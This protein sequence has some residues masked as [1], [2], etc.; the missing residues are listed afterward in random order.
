[1]RLWLRYSRGRVTYTGRL[2]RAPFV[3]W[4][5]TTEGRTVLDRIA[6][7]IRFSLIGR[8]LAARHRVWRRLVAM[9]RDEAVVA[10]VQSEAQ[11]YLERPGRFA[12]ADGLPRIG[13]SLHRLVVIPRVLLNGAAYRGIAGKLTACP[14]F[15]TLE[16]GESLRDFF[17]L[18]L[19]EHLDTAVAAARP[20]P[21]RPLPAGDCWM[22]VGMNGRFV[23]RVPVVKS[24]PW[25]GH[26]YVLELTRDP[27][28]RRLRK[29]VSAAIDQLEASLKTLSRDA[30]QDIVRRAQSSV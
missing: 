30:R 4:T 5:E 9:A 7:T 17:I 25:D 29:A 27:V 24:P 22:T 18:T 2:N 21:K 3:A 1:M 10:C 11:A 23:W 13:V 16:G 28:T 20:T 8:K 19:V 14:A 26:H 15:A 12:Y 6:S